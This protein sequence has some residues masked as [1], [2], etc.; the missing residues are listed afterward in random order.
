MTIT[1]M[2][3]PIISDKEELNANVPKKANRQKDE[4]K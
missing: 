2:E 3:L 4:A 1:G